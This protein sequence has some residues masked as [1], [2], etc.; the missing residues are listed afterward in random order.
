MPGGEQV[1][2]DVGHS[3]MA[4]PTPVAVE[5]E[6]HHE[7]VWPSWIEQLADWWLWFFRSSTGWGKWQ[8]NESTEHGSEPHMMK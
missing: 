3:D 6:A 1:G 2:V 8:P 7:K 4:I 5:I